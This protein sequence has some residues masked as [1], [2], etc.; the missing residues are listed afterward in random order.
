[1]CESLEKAPTLHAF[2][3]AGLGKAPFR[4]VGCRKNVFVACPGAPPKAGGTCDYCSQGI[5]Y[6]CVI[7]SSD[8]KTFVVGCDCVRRTNV[9]NRVLSEM[10]RGF[11]QLK[12]AERD[13][14]REAKWQEERARLEAE[15]QKQRDRNGG[16]TDDQLARKAEEARHQANMAKIVKLNGWL[17]DVLAKVNQGPFVESMQQEL[18]RRTICNLSE[19]ARYVLREIYQKAVGGRSDKKRTEAGHDFDAKVEEVRAK[20][21]EILNEGK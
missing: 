17:L 9:N 10:E 12:K 14:K 13:A 2:E 16:L 18:G 7:K 20:A 19:R 15:L 5:M 4:Y 8:G 21:A 1:M 3:V 6:E 11:A